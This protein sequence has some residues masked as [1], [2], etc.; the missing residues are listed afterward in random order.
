[1]VNRKLH[2]GKLHLKK[3]QLGKLDLGKLALLLTFIVLLS[4]NMSG[5]GV[6]VDAPSTFTGEAQSVK[7]LGTVVLRETVDPWDPYLK[8]TKMVPAP[9][10]EDQLVGDDLATEKK[11]QLKATWDQKAQGDNS[12]EITTSGPGPELKTNFEGNTFNLYAPADNTIAVSVTGQ[13]ISGTNARIHTYTETGSSLGATTLSGFFSGLPGI[14]PFKFDPKVIYDIAEDR[15]IV[16]CLAAFDSTNSRIL[17]G[18]S[19]SADPG[20]SYNLYALDGNPFNNGL[21]TDYPQLGLNQNEFFVTGNLFT[22]ANSP[23]FVQNVIWQIDKYDGYSGIAL[24][25]VAHSNSYFSV[26]PVTGATSLY[27]PQMYFVSSEIGNPSIMYLHII[28]NSIDNGGILQSPNAFTISPAIGNSVVVNQPDP[29]QDFP[30]AGTRVRDSYY[31]NN[32]IEFVMN[33]SVV[34]RPAVYHGTA[35]LSPLGP[36]FSNFTGQ[37]IFYNDIEIAYP[38]IAYGGSQHSGGKNRSYIGFNFCSETEFPSNG[39]CFVDESGFSDYITCRSGESYVI[40]ISPGQD[41]R[42]GDYTSIVNRPGIP[43]EAWMAASY[44]N[45]Q[46]R[47]V[48]HISQ[49]NLPVQVAVDKPAPIDRD[50]KVYPNPVVEERVMFTFPVKEYGRYDLVIRDVEGRE[51]KR[52]EEYTLR[53]GDATIHFKTGS[54]PKGIYFVTVEGGDGSVFKGKFVVN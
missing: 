13:M 10:G 35:F 30:S 40:P 43:G 11:H 25:F 19:Q 21:W 34:G 26:H 54:L 52:W 6:K 7:R 42:W 49:L 1:M 38:C 18:F 47:E 2:L 46:G 8:T 36:G 33:S 4:F 24:D 22:D 53:I 5:Q 16:V 50:L 44:G 32:R 15:F 17:V 31:E 39:A 3:L 51:I 9:R 45:S 23:Q 29:G 14:V 48:T 20:G 41:I 28:D 37:L 12:K 27:G